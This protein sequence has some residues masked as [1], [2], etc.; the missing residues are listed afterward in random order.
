MKTLRLMWVLMI[1]GLAGCAIT[2]ARTGDQTGPPDPNVVN[3]LVPVEAVAEAGVGVLGVLSMLWPGLLPVAT[4]AGGILGT[5]KKLRPQ[6][7]AKTNEADSY[8]KAGELLTEA[9]EDIKTNQPET[10]K[11]VGPA[12]TKALAP[13]SKAENVIRGFRGLEPKAIV[14]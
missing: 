13:V 7:V 2:P 12:I 5:Y 4:A 3:K 11:V 8:Y 9:L 1:L 6:V 14:N 10:W